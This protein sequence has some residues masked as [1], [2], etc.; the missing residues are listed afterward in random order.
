MYKMLGDNK[1][2]LFKIYFN[3]FKDVMHGRERIPFTLVEEY[4]NELCFLEWKNTCMIHSINPK[5]HWLP[6]F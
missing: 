6:I 5:I 1:D 3:R 4:K 2:D